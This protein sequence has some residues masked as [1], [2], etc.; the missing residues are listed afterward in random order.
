MYRKMVP[1]T[2][3]IKK[4]TLYLVLLYLYLAWDIVLNSP[5]HS[6]IPWDMI[7]HSA[8]F[9]NAPD[10]RRAVSRFRDWSLTY[11]TNGPSYR[12]SY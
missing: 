2:R 4:N 10:L 1:K 7:F 9:L 5:L 3:A 8:N 12:N 11:I 6:I